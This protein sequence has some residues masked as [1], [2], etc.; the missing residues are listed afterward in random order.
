MGNLVVT[1][2]HGGADKHLRVVRVVAE[3]GLALNDR[4][5]WI[6]ENAGS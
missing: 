3:G 1:Q 5:L 2:V 6:H 4:G